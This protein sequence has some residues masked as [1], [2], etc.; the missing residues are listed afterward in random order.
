MIK[1]VLFQ[2]A[3]VVVAALV[4]GALIVAVSVVHPAH[5]NTSNG[6]IIS[7]ILV[8]IAGSLSTLDWLYS[9]LFDR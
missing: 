5:T 3:V 8:V 2:I 9:A 4:A 7:G 1:K 6:V